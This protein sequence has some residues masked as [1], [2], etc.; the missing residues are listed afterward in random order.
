MILKLTDT[1]IQRLL[2]QNM[3][4]SKW[5]SYQALFDSKVSSTIRNYMYDIENLKCLNKVDGD[6]AAT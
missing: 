5:A 4:N 1:L 6:P 2:M 3:V